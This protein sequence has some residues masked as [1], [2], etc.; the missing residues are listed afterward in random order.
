MSYPG[1]TSSYD[2]MSDMLMQYLLLSEMQRIQQT[3]Q[4]QQSGIKDIAKAGKS[5]YGALKDLGA[6]GGSSAAGAGTA[7]AAGAGTTAG[8]GALSSAGSGAGGLMAGN[9]LMSQ[10]PGSMMMSSSAGAGSAGGAGAGGAGGAG[11]GSVLVPAAAIAATAFGANRLYD[12]WGKGGAKGRKRGLEGGAS[13]GAGIGTLMAPGIGTLVGAGIG[14]LGGLALGSIKA[15]KHSDQIKRDD[16]RSNLKSAGIIDDKYNLSLADGRKFDIGI[17]GG[18]RPY[19]VDFNKAGAGEAVG[20]ANPLSAIFTNADPKLKSD[21]AGYFANAAMSGGDAKKN[22]RAI[23]DKAGLDQREAYDAVNQ[24]QIDDD[25]KRAY[26]NAINQAF[27]NQ[28]F[29]ASG[30]IIGAA[31]APS[32]TMIPRTGRKAPDYKPGP[33][34]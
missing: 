15:G 22:I 32:N 4:P 31:P 1:M 34:R 16:V 6:I 8:A 33:R 2:P 10:A 5:G 18:S 27:G 13:L 28:G 11:A 9:G 12:N 19:N 26:H 25:T 14:S 24:L 20:L 21:F 29:S 7:T 23:Y 17:D 3:Q 30:G